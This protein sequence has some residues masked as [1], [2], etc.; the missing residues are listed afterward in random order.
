MSDYSFTKSDVNIDRLEQEIADEALAYS[1]TQSVLRG[2]QLSI[3]FDGTLSEGNEATLSAV[4]ANH[5]APAQ[6]IGS[7]MLELKDGVDAPTNDSSGSVRIFVDVTDG[8]LKVRF[9]DGHTVTL[10]LDQ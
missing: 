5:A 1:V 9:G 8:N 7:D 6:L 4:V 3:S 10:A 2:D